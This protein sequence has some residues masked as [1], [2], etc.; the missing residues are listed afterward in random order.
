M[1]NDIFITD[2]RLGFSLSL[3][4]FLRVQGMRVCITVDEKEKKNTEDDKTIGP[5]IAWNRAS[6]FSAQSIPL[7]LKNIGADIAAA[8][9]IFDAAAYLHIYA[10]KDILAADTVIT[11]LIT[12]NFQLVTV[13]IRYFMQKNTGKLIFV[14]RDIPFSCGH[15]PLAAASGAFIRMAEET[16]MNIAKEEQSCIQTMLVRLEGEENALYVDWLSTQ[17]Q[18]SVLTRTPGRW[19]KA[20]QRGLFSK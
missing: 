16:V 10:E 6:A 1:N 5:L 3:A 7:Q 12:A 19:I 9:I 17:I 11:D 20:G 18:S 2:S 8:I 13:L 14:H 4:D 15:P